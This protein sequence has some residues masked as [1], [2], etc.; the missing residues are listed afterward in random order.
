MEIN[1]CFA[2]D[3]N[4]AQHTGCVIASILKNSDISDKYNFYIISNGIADKN[5]EFFEK[6]KSIRDFE[7]SFLDVD[8]KDFGGIDLNHLG[9]PTL[10]RFKIFELINKDKILYLDS[11]MVVRKNLRE[12]YETDITDYLWAG[13][14]D[15]LNPYCKYKFKMRPD[16]TY[17]N[18]GVVLLN[19]KKCREE[20]ISEKLFELAQSAW[21]KRDKLND[22][23]MINIVSQAQIKIVDFKWNCMYCYNNYYSSE[24][25]YHEMA[26]DPSISHYITE[27]KPWVAGS[28]PYNKEEYFEYLKLTPWYSE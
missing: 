27:N 20:N 15:I 28:N 21:Q 24:E 16:S 22:Q 7:L 11:D 26:K 17:I 3:N 8:N 1:V 19:L 5:K 23:D 12:L 9:Y 4:Y 18:A 13:V 25:E 6:L 2:I 14:E 10:Y